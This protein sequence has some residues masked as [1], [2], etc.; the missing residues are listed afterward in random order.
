[1]PFV[2]L[3]FRSPCSKRL[4]HT[5]CKAAPRLARAW[6]NVKSHI[7]PDQHKRGLNAYSDAGR[8]A[9]PQRIK[10]SDRRINVTGIQK[11]HSAETPEERESQLL[12]DNQETIAR[13][14]ELVLLKTT[15][16]CP[17]ACT[18]S[19][20]GN[21]VLVVEPSGGADPESARPNEMSPD[22]LKSE[23]LREVS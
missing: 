7:E 19:F 23:V 6:E 18:E 16:R 1:M 14:R 21:E 2:L 20:G 13:R 10:V 8:I 11:A 12:I 22:G 4:S 17:A 15:Q 3:V 5:K 9:E